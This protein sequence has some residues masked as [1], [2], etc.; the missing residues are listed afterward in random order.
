MKYKFYYGEKPKLT[1][2]DLDNFS[3]GNYE[4]REL[5]KDGKGQP[6]LL[7]KNT[8]ADVPVWK[9]VYAFS[10]IVFSSYDEAM[11]FCEDRFSK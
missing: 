2:T 4:C 1:N 11:A 7:M 6:V 3:G 9:V 10:T 8:K 5:M